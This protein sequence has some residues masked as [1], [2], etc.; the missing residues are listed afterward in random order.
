[1]KRVGKTIV[2]D[3]PPYVLSSAGIVGKKEG[4]GP[5]GLFFDKIINDG[6]FG[7]KTWEKAESRFLRTAI[8]EA[9]KKASLK[10]HD[11]DVLLSGDLLNQ[12]C[13]ST[14]ACVDMS[15]PFLGLFGA[16]STMAEGLVIGSVLVES[17]AVGKAICSASSHYC[18]AERQFRFPLGYGAQRAPTAQWTT[19]AAGAFILG[20]DSTQ[21]SKICIT[22]A[23]I[24][25]PCDLGIKD[26]ANMGAAMA[27]SAYNSLRQFFADTNTTFGD[28]DIVATG[29]LGQV[30]FDMVTE[31][32]LRDG[33]TELANYNDC[34]LL[35]FDIDKQDVHA[36]G[37]GCGCSASVGASYIMHRL[38]NGDWKKAVLASTGALM[39]P[40]SAQQGSNIVG[41]THIVSFEVRA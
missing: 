24:G 39:S 32:F 2:F 19:T 36:G 21:S 12:C 37:S 15:I 3:S 10:Y 33:V 16:C 38:R 6:Y 34:G 7:E 5:L 11:I 18:S 30:G 9:L 25:T 22:H 20:Y 13:A 28:Y 29:D 17:G 4:E 23:L 14:F 31:L 35:I 26:A 27:P 40:T 1:M 41:V 8:D